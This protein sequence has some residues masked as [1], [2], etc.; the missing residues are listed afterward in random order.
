MTL[1]I[2]IIS[3]IVSFLYGI[4]FS[5]ILNINYK[6]IYNSKKY[7]SIVGTFVFII[8]NSLLYFLILMKINHGIIHIYC[9]L[10]LLIGFILEHFFIHKAVAS[11]LKK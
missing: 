9:L 3:L 5:W 11:I 2:Q 6:L 10:A 8:C 1:K 7:I 4:L